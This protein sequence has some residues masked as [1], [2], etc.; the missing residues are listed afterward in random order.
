[1]KQVIKR[2]LLATKQQPQRSYTNYC[3]E[4]EII[5]IIIIIVGVEFYGTRK[6]A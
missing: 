4:K 6:Q 3:S 2:A 1:M 5:I